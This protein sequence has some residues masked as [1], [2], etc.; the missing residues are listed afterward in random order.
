MCICMWVCGDEHGVGLLSMWYGDGWGMECV[1]MCGIAGPESMLWV[2]YMVSWFLPLL[3]E[4]VTKCPVE[5][6]LE[7][8]ASVRTER[9][10][11][12]KEGPSISIQSPTDECGGG[13]LHFHL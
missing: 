11:F 1:Y 3:N 2:V 10:R 12:V 4:F 13:Y 8:K 7:A 9:L 5:S 6:V